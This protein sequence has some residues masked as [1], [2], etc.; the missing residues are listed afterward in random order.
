MIDLSDNIRN[1]IKNEVNKNHFFIL[2]DTF[3][4]LIEQIFKN[5]EKLNGLHQ[6]FHNIPKE[7]EM[8]FVAAPTGAGKD[9]LVVKLNVLNPEK[10]YIELNMDMFRHYFSI[11]IP[12]MSKITDKTFAEQTNEFSYEMYYT[13]QEILLSEFPG[14]NIIITGTLWKTDWVEQTFKKY[15]SNQYTNYNVKLISL[16]VPYKESAI[17]IISRYANIVDLHI[18]EPGTA[19]YTSKDYHDETF[20]RFP[21][22]LKYFEDLYLKNPGELIDSMEVYRRSKDMHD[23]YED[24]LVYSSTRKTNE[25]Q[26]AVDA[27]LKIREKNT[28]FNKDDILELMYIISRNREY[29]KNQGVFNDIVI[30]IGQLLGLIN[31]KIPDGIEDTQK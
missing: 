9:S 29:L 21:I 7:A 27:I 14:T 20:K 12:D 24:T 10:N 15:K 13:I 2:D 28:D 26:N 11:V 6:D 30:D 16:A 3:V 25:S 5:Y 19:R 17:S 4:P 22:N 18:N 31:E 23:Y 1:V 8:I